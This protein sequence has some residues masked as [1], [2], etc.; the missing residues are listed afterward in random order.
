M[1][2]FFVGLPLLTMVVVIF[3]PRLFKTSLLSIVL[4]NSSTQY[5]SAQS[6]KWTSYPLYNAVQSYHLACYKAVC[7]VWARWQVCCTNRM[8]LLWLHH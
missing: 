3:Y 2:K 7:F 4:W 6:F 5:L 1:Q 8:V